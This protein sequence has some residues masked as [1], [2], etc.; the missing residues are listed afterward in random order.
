MFVLGTGGFLRSEGSEGFRVA[1]RAEVRNPVAVEGVR[2][3]YGGFQGASEESG[4]LMI[5]FDMGSPTY[6]G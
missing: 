6:R 4:G 5:F 3:T 1:R 2:A